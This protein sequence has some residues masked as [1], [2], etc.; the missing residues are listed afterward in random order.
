MEDGKSFVRMRGLGVFCDIR[1][2]KKTGD[3]SKNSC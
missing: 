3:F 1:D 2:Q